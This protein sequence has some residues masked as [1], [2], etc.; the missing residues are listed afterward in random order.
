MFEFEQGQFLHTK[1]PTTYSLG[2][3]HV[4]VA[5]WTFSIVNQHLVAPS[6]AIYYLAKMHQTT[7]V[8]SSR[9]I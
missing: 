5:S 2:L 8:K 1:M 7:Y 3:V 9:P 4:T 6:N